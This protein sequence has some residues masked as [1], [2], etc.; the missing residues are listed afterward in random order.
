MRSEKRL[1]DGGLPASRRC[2]R[3]DPLVLIMKYS[4]ASL[5]AGEHRRDDRVW[6][7]SAALHESEIGTSLSIPNVCSTVAI[8]GKADMPQTSRNRRS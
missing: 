8:E 5:A 3:G 7:S 2:W 4:L 6:T 1:A